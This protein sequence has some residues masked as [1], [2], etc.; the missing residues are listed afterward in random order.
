MRIESQTTGAPVDA[1][2][3]ALGALI[4]IG[5]WETATYLAAPS[6][7]PAHARTPWL[8]I[9]W[10]ARAENS[11]LHAALPAFVVGVISTAAGVA[12]VLGGARSRGEKPAPQ[13]HGSARLATTAELRAEGLGTQGVVVC[14][15][16]S[17]KL[18][19]V[20]HPGREPSWR[21]GREAP[22]ICIPRLHLLVEASTGGGK[23]E[24]IIL[25][26]ALSD[27]RSMVLLDPAYDIHEQSAGWR[28]TFSYTLQL[29]PTRRGGAGFNPLLEIPRG[30]GE[31]GESER[32]ARVL[33][34]SSEREGMEGLVYWQGAEQLITAASLFVLHY[35]DRKSLPGVLEY[36]SNPRQAQR[37]IVV[38]MAECAN[39]N[40]RVVARKLLRS[41][42]QD[43]RAINGAFTTAMNVLSFC[44]DPITA[45]MLDRS[46]FVASDLNQLD[47]PLSL[48]I[49]VPF[50]NADRLTPLTRLITNVLVHGLSSRMERKQDVVVM[51]D[52]FDTLGPVP[53]IENGITTLRKYG[54][55]FVLI[56]QSRAQIRAT[57]KERAPVIFDNC[58]AQLAFGINSYESAKYLSDLMGKRTEV[59]A[60]HSKGV[61]RRN[62]LD[63][64]HTDTHAETEHGRELLT[65]DEVRTMPRDK[66]LLSVGGLHPYLGV[67]VT[68]HA[69]RRFADR[70]KIPAPTSM[71]GE[72]PPQRANP[73]TQAA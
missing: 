27:T 63:S 66:V 47:T 1:C 5:G 45:D 14:Q 43:R 28:S 48:Y 29:T 41:S 37:D 7:G 36:L 2:M 51:L 53:A 67:L 65:A 16:D 58:L 34:R 71:V 46:D 35:R 24:G 6:F 72:R 59:Q 15:E 31:L 11:A 70:A 22:L 33:C 49:S 39:E 4:V 62:L 3:R 50:R 30:E 10:F 18:I 32:I 57:Y 44:S 8:W 17:A 61:T 26:T 19:R 23:G 54:V 21:V 69:D 73:W 60:R 68:R 40:V 55:Q 20:L 52:E 12:L 42:E 64:S 25:P 38:Q 13:S 56:T 9:V